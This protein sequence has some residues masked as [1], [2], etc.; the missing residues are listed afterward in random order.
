MS[1]WIGVQIGFNILLAIGFF[2]VWK[3]FH[4][5]SQQDDP[6]LSKGLQL[7]QS[8]IAILED[9]SDRTETQSRQL[10]A[11]MERKSVEVQESIHNSQMQI[12][13]IEMAMQKSLEVAT[14]F[15][16]KIPHQE[17]IERQSTAKY[18]KAAVLAHQGKSA[19]EIAAEID[20]PLGE[21]EF[22]VKVNKDQLVFSEESLPEW[23][24]PKVEMPS[25]KRD[26]SK[27]FSSPTV[28]SENLRKIGEQ[29]REAVAAKDPIPPIPKKEVKPYQFKKINFNDNL[30]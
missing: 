21:L 2:A 24:R 7:L 27:A 3:K 28:D 4:T 13:K 15:Q 1:T 10:V 6:R 8:K 26:F 30:G 23:A 14:I 9:L 11:L 29:F 19:Q 16:D 20:I 25:P 5:Q 12:Q 22:I 18:I 17:I